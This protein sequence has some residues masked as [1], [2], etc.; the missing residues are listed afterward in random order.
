MAGSFSGWSI[1]EAG[2]V[3][4]P[5]E[6]VV[7]APSPRKVSGKLVVATAMA[8]QVAVVRLFAELFS[9]RAGRLRTAMP[10]LVKCTRR[11][12]STLTSQR[13][14]RSSER[15]NSWSGTMNRSPTSYR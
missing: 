3:Q 11:I 10:V 14:A 9:A 7:S 6:V 13:L 2:G 5:V 4:R 15:I 12:P 8:S 1:G